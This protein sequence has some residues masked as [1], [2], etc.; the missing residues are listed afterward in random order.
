LPVCKRPVWELR[1][2]SNSR[3]WALLQRPALGSPMC[4]PLTLAALGLQTLTHLN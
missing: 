4:W 3:M 1:V 2:F